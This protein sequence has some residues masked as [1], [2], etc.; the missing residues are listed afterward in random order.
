MCHHFFIHLSTD[1]PLGCFHILAIVN[2]AAVNIGVLMF[3]WISVFGSFKYIQVG[4]LGQKA[5]PFLIFWGI[6]ILNS[7]VAAPIC[8]PTN[9]AKGFPFLHILTSTCC[10]LIYWWYSHSDRCEMVSYCGFNLHLSDD[11]WRWACFHMS[12]GH[13]YVLFG[14]V[15][16]QVLCP[17]FNW[18]VCLC[19]CW[20]L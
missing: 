4:L 9:S 13:R 18:V 19:W 17:L 5:D 20:V 1:G 7:T 2:N 8:I 10:L 16:I 12:I 15:S 11:W 6:S 14:E 3:F